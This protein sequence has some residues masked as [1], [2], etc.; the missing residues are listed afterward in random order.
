MIRKIFG[1]FIL[2]M[3][4]IASFIPLVS[5]EKIIN[6]TENVNLNFALGQIIIKT[7]EGINLD[8]LEKEGEITTGFKS[9]DNLN[10]KYHVSNFKLTIHSKIQP[11]NQE[12]SKSLGLDRFY[13]IEFNKDIDVFNVIE[14]YKKV[15]LIESAGVSSFG[16]AADSTATFPNDANFAWQWG[17]HSNGSNPP[18]KPGA[19]DADIDAPEGWD[20]ETGNHNIVVAIIDKG[21]DWTHTDI[22]YNIWI[23]T[24]EDAW[25]NPYDYTTGNGLDDDGNG[26]IDDWKGWNIIAN[27]SNSQDESSDG[28]GTHCAGIAGAVTNNNYGIAGVNWYSKLMAVRAMYKNGD[29]YWTDAAAALI[30]AA[31][32]GADV[33]SMSFGGY[34]DTSQVLKGGIDYA[35]NSG[36]ILVAAMGNDGEE[37]NHYPAVYSNVIAV[38][39]TDVDDSRARKGDWANS[40]EGSN[41]GNHIDVIAPG[42]WIY[43]TIN[44]NQFEYKNGTS[45][46][47]PHVAGLAALLLSQKPS[48]TNVKVREIIRNTADDQVG[49]PFEDIK[50]FDKHHGY[51]RI[52][53]YNALYNAPYQPLKPSG[54]SSG[55]KGT[56][57]TYTS[58]A[59]DPDGDNIYL[60]FDWGD[61]TNSGWV[62]PFGSGNTG[63]ASHSWASDDSYDIKVKAKDINNKESSWSDTLSVTIPRDK[64]T[65]NIIVLRLLERFPLLQTLLINS[66]LLFKSEFCS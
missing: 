53:V 38:G 43:S 47:T 46:A 28:H 66:I 11:K 23:N 36:C 18:P 32:N 15:S 22:N 57:Y 14:D 30:Y 3:L 60:W 51:G 17:L 49:L 13:T 5:T 58:S 62:G 41:F 64:A 40:D 59:I 65:N 52:N 48:R 7:K 54:P 44:S 29:I 19:V 24:G 56:T 9:I 35:Y 55:K 27:N 16:F 37:K 12:L 6:K 50:G 45:M 20:I 26:F 21:I 25:S 4:F 8:F 42:T 10:Q 61:G 33:I 63:S 31:D 34:S 2:I 1:I 39:A